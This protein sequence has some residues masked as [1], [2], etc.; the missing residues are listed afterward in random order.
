VAT[1]TVLKSLNV[2]L[3]P[4]TMLPLPTGQPF[5]LGSVGESMMITAF[6]PFATLIVVLLPVVK[7]Q[8]L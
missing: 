8:K 7:L 1:G 5:E 4:R 6:T 2:T 3:L